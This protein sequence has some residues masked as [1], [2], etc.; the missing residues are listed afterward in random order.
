M[1]NDSVIIF[2]KELKNIFKDK[3]TIFAIFI[4]PLILM[5]VIF[6]SISYVSTLQEKDAEE[7]VYNII[8]ENSG[9]PVF[10]DML[11]SSLQFS[12]NEDEYNADTDLRIV[13]PKGYRPGDISTV[14]I[15]YN[16]LSSKAKYAADVIAGILNSYESSI[17][18]KML[19]S[20]G[21]SLSELDNINTEKID[22]APEESQGTDFLSMMIPY[23]ILIYI[24]SGSMSIGLDTTAGEKDRGS[25]ASLLVNQVSRSS[26]ALGKVFYVIVAGLMNSISSFLGLII[27]F[28]INSKFFGD[29]VFGGNMNIFTLSNILT[30]LVSLLTLSGIAASLI[31]FL[32]SLA[33]NMREASGYITP[34]Y[35]IVIV[36]GVVTMTMDS[37]MGTGLFFIPIINSVFSMKEILTNQL[38][39]VHFI[40]STVINLGFISVLVY[41][42]SK[43]FNSER[44][45]NTI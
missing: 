10:E 19:E 22:T 14:K 32:G 1:F 25:L 9:D 16:S 11:R 26:I 24:F 45:I 30:L 2:R 42:T 3:R 39:T 17:N 7:N 37:T 12:E 34:I 18:Q 21:L 13:F 5:P 23:M 28:S 27:A 4:L 41:F 6:S 8:I 44:I 31:V 36:M 29:G 38:N 40:I 35:I 33:R 43:L 15:Y 20:H